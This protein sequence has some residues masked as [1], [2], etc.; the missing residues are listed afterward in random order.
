M[1]SIN[2]LPPARI[3]GANRASKAKK[4]NEASKGSSEVAQTTK[5]ATAVSN[6]IRQMDPSD[7]HRAQVQYDLPEGRSRKALEEYMDVM[8]QARKEELAQMLGVDIYI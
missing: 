7:I 5:V 3:P 2:G 6:S 4:K 8:N 1:V